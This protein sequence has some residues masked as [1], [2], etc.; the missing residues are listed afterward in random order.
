MTTHDF[1]WHRIDGELTPHWREC[2]CTEC[3][4]QVESTAA[5]ERSDHY[6]DLRE[7][8]LREYLLGVDA[9][10]LRDAIDKILGGDK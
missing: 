3:L 1:G 7:R 9:L 8:L 4:E 10:R 6:L 2:D 5:V